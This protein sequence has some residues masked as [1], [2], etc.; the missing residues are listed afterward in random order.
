MKKLILL[1]LINLLFFSA[2]TAQQKLK[3]NQQIILKG[4]VVDYAAKDYLYY[5][6]GQ[7]KFNVKDKVK[8][9]KDKYYI[10]NLSQTKFKQANQIYFSLD[11]GVNILSSFGCFSVINFGAIRNYYKDSKGKPIVVPN[12]FET[13]FNCIISDLPPISEKVKQ[14][15]GKY[16]LNIQDTIYQ[17]EFNNLYFTTFTGS[18]YPTDK[19]LFNSVWGYWDYKEKEN[20]L[21]LNVY[22]LKNTNFN[23]QIFTSRNWT[24]QVANDAAIISF[25]QINGT[26][27]L[28]KLK[29]P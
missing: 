10:F 17:L 9:T 29:L 11:T 18:M 28:K 15:G 3:S 13:T 4:K 16:T 19:K 2:L 1:H 25:K 21:I 22:L 5:T 6:D 8:L 20:Q 12:D 23:T 24:F 26:G 14:F 27:V 7:S